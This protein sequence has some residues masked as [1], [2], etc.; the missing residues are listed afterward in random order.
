MN[1]KI[2]LLATAAC[3]GVVACGQDE[4]SIMTEREEG[5]AGATVAQS[6]P[7]PLG[8][9]PSVAQNQNSRTDG[10]GAAPP[11]QPGQGGLGQTPAA[12]A[13]QDALA[14]PVGQANAAIVGGDTEAYVRNAALSDMY[15]IEAARIALSR[16]QSAD[17]HLIAR[18]LM[19]DHRAMS[20]AVKDATLATD[21]VFVPPA[22][23]DER[24][25]GLVD[26]LEAAAVD[27]FDEVFLDQQE[28]AHEEALNLHESYRDR[29]DVAGL[30]TVAMDAIPVIEGH[31]ERI[32][33]AQ[34]AMDDAPNAAAE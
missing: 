31:L 6:E 28:A 7:A 5:P 29:G 33:A 9:P 4:T 12:N 13:V 3:I 11:A 22:S 10:F 30:R 26:N 1:I 8:A 17:I 27:E 32:R 25:Q 2:A 23:L 20:N 15:E 24:R 21:V 34:E 18:T 16:S 14:G 19:D